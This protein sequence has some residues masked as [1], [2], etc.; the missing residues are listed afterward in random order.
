MY[1]KI[2]R[3]NGRESEGWR[4]NEECEWEGEGRKHAHRM[5]NI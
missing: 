5:E 2:A 1:Y 3:K 4:G